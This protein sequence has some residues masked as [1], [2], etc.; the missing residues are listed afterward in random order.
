MNDSDAWALQSS[1]IPL[2]EH[3]HKVF[4]CISFLKTSCHGR[5]PVMISRSLGW[6][7]ISVMS[8]FD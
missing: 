8:F 7:W 4:S 6:S 5:F 2:V 3:H 1:C